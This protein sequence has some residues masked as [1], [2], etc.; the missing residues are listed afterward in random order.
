MFQKPQFAV[1]LTLAILS[2]ASGCHC[3]P[4]VRYRNPHAADYESACTCGLSDCMECQ[5]RREKKNKVPWPLFHSLPT[6]PVFEGGGAMPMAAP[7][8]PE[9]M[10]MLPPLRPLPSSGAAEP[11]DTPPTQQEASPPGINYSV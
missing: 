3:F 2:I 9:A 4:S 5:H 1:F 6:R 11:I 10:E 7:C 8:D